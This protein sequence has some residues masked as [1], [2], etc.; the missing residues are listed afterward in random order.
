M[1]DLEKIFNPE[2][3][4]IVGASESPGKVG[5]VIAKN[6]LELGYAGKVFLV[7]PNHENILGQKGYKSLKDIQEKVDL[8]IMA[9]P[10]D[11]VLE[12]IRENAEKIKNYIIISA[13][14][15][16]IG[17]AGKKKEEDLKKLAEENDLNILGPNC[18]GIIN[19]EIKMNA[20]FAGG[21]PKVGGVSLISQS[22]AL[23]VALMDVAQE[24]G[25]KF[26]NVVSVGN[27]MQISETE[28]L[29]FCE[30]DE[31]TKVVGMYLEGIK[32]G[33]KF[34]QV[35]EKI[36]R[37]K[38]VIILKSGKTE[39]SQKTIS[40]HTG[41]LA[42]SDEIIEAV[43][44]KTGIIR[45][46]NMGEFLVL[47]KMASVCPPPSNEKVVILTNAGGLGVLAADSFKNKQIELLEIKKE[48]REKL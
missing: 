25:I 9:I 8:A 21:M 35:A 7:N 48:T 10:S 39:K 4:A 41:A 38:P 40:S 12:I 14:F 17:K 45:A 32:E 37:K 42:G 28:L 46:E 23:A 18:L 47:I 1:A 24:E 34:I 36:S 27:K 13:G 22:G 33:R 5:N 44:S 2:S 20:S 15:S 29:E 30:K 11:L 43:F 19:P 16:E 3:I 31:K 6:I 26:R